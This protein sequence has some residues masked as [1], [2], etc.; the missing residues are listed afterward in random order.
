[1][2][3]SLLLTGCSRDD[4]GK[5]DAAANGQVVELEG[6]Q[7]QYGW[8][9]HMRLTFNGD[10][11]TEVY[12]DYIDDN[13]AKKSD[14]EEYNSTMKEKTGARRQ[15]ST[16]DASP[17]SYCCTKSN[18]SRYCNRCNTQTS[19]EFM[20]M[21]DQA[22]KQ[23]FNGEVS[24]NNYGNGNPNTTTDDKGITDDKQVQEQKP[25]G[26]N[27]P[28]YDNA[29]GWKPDIHLKTIKTQK[30]AT[31]QPLHQKVRGESGGGAGAGGGGATAT[32]E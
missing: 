30:V 29:W 11:L 9:P 2:R 10:T 19:T 26:E 14:D 6:Q 27:A 20:A 24:A 16:G 3:S 5:V 32:A 7:D 12:F 13:G 4:Q 8:F 22:Y 31:K 28:T 18:S 15:R 1:M 21:A 17:K 23:Y 25:E